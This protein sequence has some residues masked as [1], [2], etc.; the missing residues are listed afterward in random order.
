MQSKMTSRQRVLTALSHREPD[1][2]PR[3]LGGTE[4]SGMTAY[5]LHDLLSHLQ[6]PTELKVFEPYQYVAY[7]DDRLKTKFGIDTANLTPKP[8]RWVRQTNPRGFDVLLPEGWRETTDE[9]GVTT[10]RSA[11]GREVARRPGGG[12]YFDPINPPL[13]NVSSAA[14][15]EK[16]RETMFSFDYPSFADESAD[17][18][19]Q[20]AQLLH[21]GGECVVFNLCCHVLAAGQ[22]LRGYENFM[23][24][25]MS[26]Q[27]LTA[28]L[29]D[30][31]IEG[32][33]R[34]VEKLAPLLKDSVDVVL[35]N[36]DLGTQ[37]GPMLS[38]AVYRERIKPYQ[39]ALF[40][41]VK[42]AF[43]KPILFHSCGAVRAF[44]P[45]LIEIG[46]D[47]LNPVQLSADGMDLRGLKRDFGKD[48]TFWGGGI[49][50][51]T[52]LNHA[53]PS[54]VAEAVRRSVDVLAPGGGFVFCQ[55]HNIQPDVPPGNVMAMYNALDACGTY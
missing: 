44:I 47:A 40:A 54:K 32:Y 23:V 24:D 43:G 34:R 50:T 48:L 35:L 22:L 27:K 30:C 18:L 31:L 19:R 17:D 15:I 4:S 38:P 29:L 49:D 39:R 53:S 8:K 20:R 3:D 1:R 11:D 55:V 25:L 16:Y 37:N 45:D 9:Q 52:V 26:D 36:D 21:A 28:A 41:H 14:E 46:V 5:A 7:V 2:V 6:L 12:Y 10:V 33:R 13:E 51:Q 42:R